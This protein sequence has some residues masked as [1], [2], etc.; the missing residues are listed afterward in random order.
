MQDPHQEFARK[1]SGPQF[2]EREAVGGHREWREVL[3]RMCR[4]PPLTAANQAIYDDAVA[5]HKS[6]LSG[7]KARKLYAESFAEYHLFKDVGGLDAACC[8]MLRGCD[9]GLANRFLLRNTKS[10]KVVT[11]LVNR[12]VYEDDECGHVSKTKR[13]LPRLPDTRFVAELERFFLYVLKR[14]PCVCFSFSGQNP[15]EPW[16]AGFCE[17]VVDS[18]DLRGVF[19]VPTIAETITEIAHTCLQRV[20]AQKVEEVEQ[21]SVATRKR[22]AAHMA[23]AAKRHGFGTHPMP[24]TGGTVA[25]AAG[26]VVD[27]F[28]ED[29]DLLSD[30][31]SGSGSG[32]GSDSDSDG[33]GDGK[34]NNA[35]T[36]KKARYC[37]LMDEQGEGMDLKG[38]GAWV[39]QPL[40]AGGRLVGLRLVVYYDEDGSDGGCNV[41]YDATVVQEWYDSH[42][43]PALLVR[44]DDGEVAHVTDEDEWRWAK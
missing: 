33:D 43:S 6:W 13:C 25:N 38:M 23:G 29:G 16:I 20:N 34:R 32:S 36:H 40:E 7:L 17:A 8:M 39:P 14:S 28:G 5:K 26:F 9:I 3:E 27:D 1:K 4:D 31:D 30:S 10:S 41:P 42:N 22:K 21:K 35:W 19:V 24:K 12:I 18:E 15:Y 37:Q 44:F 2:P 11:N